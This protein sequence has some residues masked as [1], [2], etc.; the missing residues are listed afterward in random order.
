MNTEDQTTSE[1]YAPGWDAI[2]SALQS[3]YGDQEPAHYGT[4]VNDRLGGPDPLDG[5]SSYCRTDPIPHF[6]LVT[7]GFSE[8]SEKESE[9]QEVSG[10]G[11]ELT[12]RPGREP[13]ETEPP[14]WVVNFL[15]NLARYVFQ[16]GNA[17]AAGHHMD[18]NGP[19]ANTKTDITAIAF[20][21]DPELPSI[22][23]PNG[24]LSFLQVV[25]LT[26]DEYVA[27]LAWDTESFLQV[28]TAYLPLGLT[29]VGRSS[30]LVEPSIAEMISSGIARDGSS[31]TSLRID[32]LKFEV[33]KRLLGAPSAEVAIGA[34]SVLQ[35]AAVLPS[36]LRHG[37]AL[38]L[39]SQ[40]F[41]VSFEAGD[42]Q[43]WVLQEPNVLAVRI[44]PQDAAQMCASLQPRSGI[45]AVPGVPNLMLRIVPSI[46]RDQ[47]GNVI[48]TIG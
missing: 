10:F 32:S 27:T 12:F 40:H 33:R 21:P 16:S 42:K 8:L 20:M 24:S 15:Q 7:Y 48:R 37:R 3:L 14:V 41:V 19:I 13:S 39:V 46:I 26:H 35:F 23:T 31:T 1:E 38:R 25:G 9:N 36:R 2:D 4:A 45:M 28:L 18:L 29:D 22:S 47:R 43:G 17:F 5:I 44:A 30:L 6:H 11:F 34:N